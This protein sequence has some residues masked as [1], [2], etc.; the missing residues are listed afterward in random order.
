MTS[1]RPAKP[2]TLASLRSHLLCLRNPTT[3]FRSA[4]TRCQSGTLQ[5]SAQLSVLGGITHRSLSQLE[6]RLGQL[7]VDDGHDGAGTLGAMRYTVG[8]IAQDVSAQRSK[9]RD[10]SGV[11]ATAAPGA[12][13]D[14]NDKLVKWREKEGEGRRAKATSKEKKRLTTARIKMT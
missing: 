13:G 1:G 14:G 9:R 10:R 12:E 3:R 4:C 6:S 5:N 2:N 7:C 8:G 11:K